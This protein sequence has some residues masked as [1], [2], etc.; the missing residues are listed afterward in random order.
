MLRAALQL[1]SVPFIRGGKLLLNRFSPPVLILLYHRVTTLESDPQLLAV[2]PDNFRAQLEYLKKHYCLARLEDDWAGVQKPAVVVTFDD[3]YADNALEALPILEELQVPATFFVSTSLIGSDREF[4]WDEVERLLLCDHGFPEFFELYH[5]GKARRWTTADAP[6]R[7]RMYTELLP[8]LREALPEM[9]DEHLERLRAWA[10]AGSQG[11]ASHR[12]LSVDELRRLAG[13]PV[14]TLGAHT[15]SHSSLSTLPASRQREEIIGSKLW[16][17]GV[18]GQEVRVF[19][20][21]FGG[22]RDYTAETVAI[23]RDA[24]FTRAA[25]NFPGQWRSNADPFQLPRHLVRNWDLPTFKEQLSRLW[26]A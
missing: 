13:S 17:E 8:L 5:D 12:V 6:A 4:W 16:L 26:I 10:G 22:R 11:R 19:S 14:A 3:G 15:L 1:G 9:R 24:G 21:P 18:L 2:T 7:L 25:S 20:Y 23:C